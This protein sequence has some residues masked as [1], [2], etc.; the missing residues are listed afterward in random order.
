M[1]MYGIDERLLREDLGVDDKEEIKL[2]QYICLVNNQELDSKVI[3]C[4]RF[5]DKKN[6]INGLFK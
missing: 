4:S 5:E 1:K 6:L 3:R 2:F